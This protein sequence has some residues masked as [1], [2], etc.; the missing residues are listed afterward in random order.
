MKILCGGS[1]ST[2][3]SV[4]LTEN[5]TIHCIN[6]ITKYTG[7]FTC[8]GKAEPLDWVFGCLHEGKPAKQDDKPQNYK[9]PNASPCLKSTTKQTL[10]FFFFFFPYNLFLTMHFINQNTSNMK[11]QEAHLVYISHFCFTVN[12]PFLPALT[13]IMLHTGRI[14]HNNQYYKFSLAPSSPNANV[15]KPLFGVIQHTFNCF[16]N[17]LKNCNLPSSFCQELQISL[18]ISL[19]KKKPTTIFS[20]S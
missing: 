2:K 4:M 6:K 1:S 13:H 8:Y 9:R 15:S 19:R 14:Q 18:L 3:E 12:F 17:N 7:M 16:I 11:I 10:C 5:T 20:S